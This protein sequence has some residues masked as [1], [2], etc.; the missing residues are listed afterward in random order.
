MKRILLKDESERLG[1]SE[2]KCE[3]YVEKLSRMIGC[4]TV[5]T[6]D[7]KYADEFAK[8]NTVLG[9]NFPNLTK[10][11]E[12]LVFGDGCFV[13]VIRGKNAKKNIMLMSGW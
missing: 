9:E 11:A 6:S 10:R 8:F 4:K 7:A 12:K 13:Y 5:W 1:V 2:E 3:E